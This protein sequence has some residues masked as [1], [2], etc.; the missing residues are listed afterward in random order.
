[1][2]QIYYLC[3]LCSF[4]LFRGVAWSE[5]SWRDRFDQDRRAAFG[6]VRSHSTEETRTF[7]ALSGENRSAAPQVIDP[8]LLQDAP[9]QAEAV[10]M[11]SETIPKPRRKTPARKAQS[12]KKMPLNDL[13]AKSRE[14]YG[15][16]QL[17]EARRFYALVQKADPQS[18]EASQRL[19]E[20]DRQ[21]Q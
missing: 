4:A 10:T 11:L 19:Q 2:K 17:E 5:S 6:A 9:A 13:L 15:G 21:M 12:A 18:A 1:M 16:G 7:Y 14:A 20:I 3:L 8:T